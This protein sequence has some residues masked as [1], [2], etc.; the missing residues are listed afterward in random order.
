MY[1]NYSDTLNK[2]DQLGIHHKNLSVRKA[3]NEFFFF[4]IVAQLRCLN[5]NFFVENHTK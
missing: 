3:Q 2:T 5:A 1:S 4:A